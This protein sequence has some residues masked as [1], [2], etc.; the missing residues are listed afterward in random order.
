MRGNVPE[1]IVFFNYS[2]LLV[3]HICERECNLY[4][5]HIILENVAYIIYSSYIYNM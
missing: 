5:I 4:N 3:S 1:F 2:L